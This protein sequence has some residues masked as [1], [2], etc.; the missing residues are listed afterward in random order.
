MHRANDIIGHMDTD[1]TQTPSAPP[2]EEPSLPEAPALPEP[3]AARRARKGGLRWLYWLPVAFALG[4]LA[5]YYFFAYPLQA[6]LAAAEKEISAQAQ[7]SQVQIP[8]N[9]KRY[10]VPVGNNPVFGP[11]DAPITIIEFSDYQCPFCQEWQQETW[12]QIQKK[13]GDKVRLVYRDFP[14]YGL[15]AAAEPSAIAAHCANEQGKYWPFHDALF[16]GNYPLERKGFESIAAQL[17]LD[18]TKFSACL[19]AQRYKAD[20]EANYKF[21]ENLGVSSTPTFFINGLALVGAQ[22][23]SVFDQVIDLELK[24]QIPKN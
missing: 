6:K 1:L 14:L 12:P 16:S 7:D 4:L 22:P 23:F 17:R 21:A 9:V 5:G 3:G 8:K 20:V 24:G 10:D 19:D 18:A 15:H 13:Y 11:S 2:A